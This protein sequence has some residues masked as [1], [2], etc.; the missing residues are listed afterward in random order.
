VWAAIAPMKA[1]AVLIDAC[2][3]NRWMNSMSLLLQF[4]LFTKVIKAAVDVAEQRSED[5]SARQPATDEKA[6]PAALTQA[7]SSQ[8]VTPSPA[9]GRHARVNLSVHSHAKDGLCKL[10]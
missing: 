7:E 4:G 10:W 5:V 3:P 6:N 9:A 8:D 1:L 2:R